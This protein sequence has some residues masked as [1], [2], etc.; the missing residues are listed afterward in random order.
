L[1]RARY[2]ATSDLAT[3]SEQLAARI[4]VIPGISSVAAA[5]VVPMNG[6]LAGATIQPPGFED[7]PST[8][9]PVTDYRMISPN[10]LVTM[11]IPLIRGRRFSDADNASGAPVAIVSHGL[12]KRYWPDANPIGSQVRVRDDM[13]KFR[14]VE[15]VGVVGDVRH[16]GLELDSPNELYVPIP[17]VPDA[18]SVWLANNMYWVAKTQGEPLT[19]ANALRREVAAVDPAVASS[20]VRSMDQW[21]AQSVDQRRFNLRLIAV[22]AVTALLL[23]AIGIYSVAAESVAVRTREMGVRSALGATDAQLVG[24]VMKGGLG[25]V[26]GGAFAGV[27]GAFLVMNALRS[28]FYGVIAHDPATFFTVFLM[29]AA[30]GTLS[31]YI[32][33]RRVTRIDPVAALRVE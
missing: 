25:P 8:K 28:F 7:Q 26:L 27:V 30:L 15:I 10:Y 17:Q 12:A 16:F 22:F 21:V 32:P 19:Y 9:W 23:A 3:F 6:Y 18:T 31:L 1:P 20:F 29:V 14:V 24:V 13:D 11:G 4:R 5:N 2:K 33:A